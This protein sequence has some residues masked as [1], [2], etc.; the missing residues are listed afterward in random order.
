MKTETMLS[1]TGIDTHAHIFCPGLP[2]AN[3]RRYA[4]DYDA[5]VD[6]YL[7]C[8][9]QAKLS[10][11]VLVQPSF[12]GT[13]NDFMLDALRRHPDRLRGIAVVD[14]AIK[15]AELDAM[16][17]CGVVGVRLNLMG[18]PL[19]D[20]REE[21]WAGLFRQLANR[22]WLVEI[23]RHAKDLPL[24]LPPIVDSGVRIVVDHFARPDPTTGIDDPGF[25]AL[26]SMASAGQL[27]VKLSAAYRNESSLVQAIEMSQRL[28]EAF[29]AEHL[30]WG[31]DW[32]HT[33]FEGQTRHADQYALLAQ[34]LADEQ[35]RQQVLVD[36]PAKL[37]RFS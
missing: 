33:Q 26:L 12:L 30:L 34:W 17:A 19:P 36:S 4:P 29:G 3:V 15:E 28:L 24:I 8:L 10:H 7:A 11:G 13:D 5:T 6:D 18:L 9:D 35:V 25:Q 20:Y 21:P 16:A 32:P 27:W 22:D 31:S 23:H 2:L 37:F 1:I 14:P